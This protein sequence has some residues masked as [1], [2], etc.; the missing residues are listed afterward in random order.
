MNVTSGT[1]RGL[2]AR[3]YRAPSFQG[4]RSPWAL[5]RAVIVRPFGPLKCPDPW[6]GI[7]CAR[8]GGHKGCPHNGTEADA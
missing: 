4:D 3:P 6:R 5:P 8:R 7:L 1:E 2:L